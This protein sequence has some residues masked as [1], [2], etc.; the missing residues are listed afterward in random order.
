V[1]PIHDG[2]RYLLESIVDQWQHELSQPA[3]GV[4]TA[5]L[6]KQFARGLPPGLA[7]VAGEQR[8]EART[9]RPMYGAVAAALAKQFSSGRAPSTAQAA[10]DQ[11]RTPRRAGVA[12]ALRPKT[13]RL[14]E[15]L[16]NTPSP[17]SLARMHAFELG[18]EALARVE[19]SAAVSAATETL[20]DARA[21][22][23]IDDAAAG[24][25]EG[26]LA[27]VAQNSD[28]PLLTLLLATLYNGV[29]S[30]LTVTENPETEPAAGRATDSL[31]LALL[32]VL[33]YADNQP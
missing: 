22:E 20:G 2:D 27:D 33:A 17:Q 10:G 28:W 16:L 31:A 12:D 23:A 13:L 11:R 7:E 1:S 26:P 6:A 24:L 5:A 9:S 8:A 29:L 32:V 14:A 25:G 18:A 15:Q 3:F 21:V 19:V 4:V 30:T